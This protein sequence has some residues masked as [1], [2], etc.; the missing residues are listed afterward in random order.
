MKIC[1]ALNVCT[2]ENLVQRF[3]CASVMNIYF[4]HWKQSWLNIREEAE[5]KTGFI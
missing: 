3:P 4:G 5:T 1:D 2:V